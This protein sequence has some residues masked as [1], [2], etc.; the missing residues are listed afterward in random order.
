MRFGLGWIPLLAK[1]KGAKNDNCYQ[2]V[3][4]ESCNL[5]SVQQQVLTIITINLL[6][7]GADSIEVE[8]ELQQLVL[9]PDRERIRRFSIQGFLVIYPVM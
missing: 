8:S 4:I 7:F 1:G 6:T 3:V 9:S 2:M 5:P